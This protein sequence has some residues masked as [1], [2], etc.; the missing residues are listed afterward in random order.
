MGIKVYVLAGADGKIN[1]YSTIQGTG[2]EVIQDDPVIDMSKLVGYEIVIG[3]DGQKHFTFN[4]EK[5]NAHVAEE[6]HKIAFEQANND[7]KQQALA[8]LSDEDAMKFQILFPEFQPGV[9]Y[10]EG[11]RV[12][13]NGRFYKVVQGHLSQEDWN[14]EAAASIFAIIGNPAEEFPEFIQPTGAHDAYAAGDKVT[15]EGAKYESLMD[16]NIYSPAEYPA[17]WQVIE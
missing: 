7:L 5:W 3:D 15:F 4:E 12:V 10:N 1:R 13:Y 9:E 2:I 14:P 16:A 17:G 6:E 11:D 8:A